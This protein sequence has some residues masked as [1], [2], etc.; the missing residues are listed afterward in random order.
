M[1][2]P[3]NAVGSVPSRLSAARTGG[4]AGVVAF[5]D[6]LEIAARDVQVLALAAPLQRLRPR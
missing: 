3:P 4:R 5:V 2:R 6:Q 1:R